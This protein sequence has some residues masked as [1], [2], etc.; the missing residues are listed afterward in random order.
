MKAGLALLW[1]MASASINTKGLS[2]WLNW[3]VGSSLESLQYQ[4]LLSKGPVSCW[5]SVS[6]WLG[7]SVRQNGL[8]FKE[9]PILTECW[10]SAVSKR[11]RKKESRRKDRVLE[12]E[13]HN[14]EQKL[15]GTS[16]YVTLTVKTAFTAVIRRSQ[17]QEVNQA[18]QPSNPP[19]KQHTEP[20]WGNAESLKLGVSGLN[21]KKPW[22]IIALLK[23][24]AFQG[25][26]K[27]MEKT[28]LK[29]P[30]EIHCLNDTTRLGFV[31]LSD[32]LLKKGTFFFHCIRVGRASVACKRPQEILL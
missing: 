7:Q 6:Q 19:S 14:L 26:Y 8:K 30:R 3:E 12:T 27:P 10:E 25:Y 31:L 20:V 28:S 22:G 21:K 5:N 32:F 23:Q 15:T 1:L 24:S 2:H 4:Q 13:E 9:E 29:G 17:E 11:D 16:I 18:Q